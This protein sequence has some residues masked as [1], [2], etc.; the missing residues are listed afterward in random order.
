MSVDP[1]YQ[2][3]GIVICLIIIVRT[4][5]AINRMSCRTITLVRLSFV[6][7]AGSAVGAILSIFG[8]AVPAP[9]FLLLAAGIAALL[10]CDRRIRFLTRAQ[11]G[12]KNAT[13]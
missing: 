4:E 2:G 8:G 11:K 1:I 3:L 10:F 6:L 9:S 5:P 7:L 13:R 12:I